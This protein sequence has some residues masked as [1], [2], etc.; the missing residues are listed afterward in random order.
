MKVR[1]AYKQHK[2]KMRVKPAASHLRGLFGMNVVTEEDPIICITEGEYDAMAVHQATGIPAVSL[3]NGAS[4][5]PV[6][7][8]PF[9]ERFAQIYLW[10][11]ADEP[12][13]AAAQKIS[14]K[15]GQ[16]RCYI[17]DSRLESQDGPKDANEA[18]KRGMRLRDFFASSQ[19]VPDKKMLQV[20]D[21]KQQLL[22]RL[23][24][25][26]ELKGIQSHYFNFFN[27]K[28][29]GLRMGEFSLV[30]GATGSGKTT[31][32]SQL[33][34]DFLAQNVPTLWGSFEI[35]NE[36]FLETMVKQY[37]QKVPK[38]EAQAR[39]AVE[40]LEQLPLHMLAFYGS[41][42]AA[43][44]FEAL[45]YSIV[46]HDISIMCLDNLQFMLSDQAFGYNKFDLQDT[47]VSKLRSLATRH[48]VHIFLVVHPKKVEDDRFLNASSIY[49]SS[50]ITQEA[51]NVF[52]LQKS[53]F[54]TPNF[55]KLQLVKNR[56]NGLVG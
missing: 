1:A 27:K 9:F 29:A 40:Q 13:R 22:F 56:H 54:D 31:F 25:E 8:L 2:A 24:N 49:G 4:S 35:K 19:T 3:P 12:G 41:T 15:L 17:I 45:E 48:N 55:R 7:L 32:L 23:R 37:S 14:K 26:A 51:D 36:I 18:L 28:C 34:L 21:V 30:T 11:D 38:N 46:A 42:P 52:I 44:I 16:A 50:K 10:L 20:S 5:L 47:V 33:S 53:E 6:E 39:E 43:E